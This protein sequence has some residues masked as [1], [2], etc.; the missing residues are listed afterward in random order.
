MCRFLL[1]KYREPQKPGLLLKEFAKACEK[2]RT[3]DGDR[4]EDGWGICFKD[5]DASWILRKSIKPIW[6]ET[7]LL[8]NMPESHL[9]ILHARSSSFASQK[10]NIEF[11]QPF[12]DKSYAFV[13]NGYLKGVNFNHS[14][15]GKIGS[16]KI[17][18]WLRSYLEIMTPEKAL[19]TLFRECQNRARSIT[20]LNLGLCDGRNIYG[21]CYYETNPEYY[22]LHFFETG[23]FSC[24]C[25]EKIL[26]SEGK[27]LKPGEII[28][29]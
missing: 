23:D 21:M 10:R 18:N 22:S 2:S 17:W 7:D 9:F 16:Q 11:N 27:V 12:I 5:K 8:L 6:E 1:I 19:F 15:K 28:I 24:L 25:S 20:A 26:P 4:Q 29:F 13:F 3:P 14:L